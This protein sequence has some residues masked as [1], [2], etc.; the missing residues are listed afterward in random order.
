M[1]EFLLVERSLPVAELEVCWGGGSFQFPGKIA[2]FPPFAGAVMVDEELG[3][4]AE[5]VSAVVI[6]PTAGRA[7][8][9]AKIASLR[10]PF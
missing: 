2:G 6:D 10:L 4:D 9:E 8:G 1:D 7:G 5:G 3:V